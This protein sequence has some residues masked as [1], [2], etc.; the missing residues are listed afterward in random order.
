MQRRTPATRP[1]RATPSPASAT[2]AAK[3]SAKAAAKTPARKAKALPTKSAA[4]PAA[5]S[6]SAPKPKVAP[7]K[8]SE[9]VATAVEIALPRPRV[10]PSRKLA[11]INTLPLA[12]SSAAIAA[13]ACTESAVDAFTALANG[14][15]GCAWKRTCGQTTATFFSLTRVKRTMRASCWKSSPES[16]PKPPKPFELVA[17]SR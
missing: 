9:K 14:V 8:P 17:C 5:P 15:P 3:P 11:S 12:L 1:S 2:S 7:P 13:S 16:K 6:A 4:K 10:S